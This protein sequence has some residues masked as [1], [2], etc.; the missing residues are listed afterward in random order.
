MGLLSRLR[1]WIFG[2]TGDDE[3]AGPPTDA[4][5]DTEADTAGSDEEPTGLD[6]GAA[7]ETRTAATDDAVDALRDVRRS[8]EASPADAGAEGPDRPGEPDEPADRASGDVGDD[9]DAS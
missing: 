2:A 8:Q 4:E 9:R 6:P 1:T 7:T 5:G 3:S